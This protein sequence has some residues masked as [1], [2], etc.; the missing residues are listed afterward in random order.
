MEY[1]SSD[2]QNLAFYLDKLD[3]GNVFLRWNATLEAN[4]RK[5][6]EQKFE[7]NQLVMNLPFV[8]KDIDKNG[9][10]FYF[11][12]IQPLFSVN[13]QINMLFNINHTST[14]VETKYILL[15][16]DYFEYQS[17]NI[18]YTFNLLINN[19]VVIEL[20]KY[21]EKQAIN[22]NEFEL[23]NSQNI[24]FI[25][26]KNIKYIKNLKVFISDALGFNVTSSGQCTLKFDSK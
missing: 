15:D 10:I 2:K 1:K 16:K 7:K 20:L 17:T 23:F 3:Y 26:F 12:I 24:S 13:F 6:E 21:T 4:G 5:W 25:S 8:K 9:K 22:L 11:L 19:D 18:I 14:N